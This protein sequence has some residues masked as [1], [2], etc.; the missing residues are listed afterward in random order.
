MEIPIKLQDMIDPN[1]ECC[2]IYHFSNKCKEWAVS[3]GYHIIEY[4][5]AVEI[6]QRKGSISLK[7]IMNEN[8]FSPE[9]VFKSCE[10]IM[11]RINEN[12]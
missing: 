3:K 12:K 1:K 4:V 7:S 8:D 9:T 5:N 10:W 2:C 11:E 6:V